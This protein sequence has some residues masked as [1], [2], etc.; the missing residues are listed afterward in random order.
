MQGFKLGIDPILL[1]QRN[2]IQFITGEE[3]RRKWH[4]DQPMEV[5]QSIIGD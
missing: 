2:N 1:G 3:N 4:F 5:V